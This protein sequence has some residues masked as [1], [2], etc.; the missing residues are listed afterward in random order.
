MMSMKMNQDQVVGCL[1]EVKPGETSGPMGTA[2]DNMPAEGS[3]KRSFGSQF[4]KLGGG[5]SPERPPNKRC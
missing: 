3:S 2:A 5:G 1:A 4:P